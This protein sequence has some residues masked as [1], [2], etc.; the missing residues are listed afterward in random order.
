MKNLVLIFL[1]LFFAQAAFSQS[2][3]KPSGRFVMTDANCAGMIFNNDT[4]ITFINEFGCSP[5][6]LRA[7]WIDAKTFITVE[8]EKVQSN[9]PP[10][11]SV[12]KI[13]SFSGSTLKL[14][15]FWVG[16]GNLPDDT[17]TMIKQK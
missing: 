14:R 3:A 5:W 13:I 1:F 8:K 15:D 6:E 16:W 4:S 2:S 7:K 10:R 17:I 9:S 11:V 12:Y